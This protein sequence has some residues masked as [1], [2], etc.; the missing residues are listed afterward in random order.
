MPV[1]RRKHQESFP[2]QKTNVVIYFKM[3]RREVTPC[4]WAHIERGEKRG[5]EG[6]RTSPWGL[7]SGEREEEREMGGK[8]DPLFKTS[9]TITIVTREVRKERNVREK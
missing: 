4:H 9:T 5:R 8:Q 7:E 6:G 2:G 3:P 1:G